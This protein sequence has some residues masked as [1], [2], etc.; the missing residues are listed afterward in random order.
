MLKLV[1]QCRLFECRL[2]MLALGYDV[3]I[4]SSTCIP[5]EKCSVV[6]IPV[7]S[8]RN[9][10]WTG[11]EAHHSPPSTDE[12]KNTWTYSSSS[13]PPNPIHIIGIIFN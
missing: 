6:S 5:Y 2:V 9:V 11:F 3:F 8:C 4:V 13:P 12:V 1:H 7:F 10:K